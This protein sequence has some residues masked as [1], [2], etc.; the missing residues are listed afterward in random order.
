MSSSPFQDRENNSLFRTFEQE[1][2]DDT[3]Y[4]NAIQKL[5]KEIAPEIQEYLIKVYQHQIIK[6][7][8]IKQMH[9]KNG[10]KDDKNI[11]KIEQNIER[12]K[13]LLEKTKQRFSL[14]EWL[15]NNNNDTNKSQIQ[16]Q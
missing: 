4:E 13:Q 11:V 7:N 15:A 3:Y 16:N 1:I 14:K 9:I 5:H 6:L 10:S 8:Q 12:S 2:N